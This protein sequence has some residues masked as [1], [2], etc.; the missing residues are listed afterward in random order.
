VDW[1]TL[2][3]PTVGL[4]LLTIPP[5][6]AHS[7]AGLSESLVVTYHPESTQA[8]EE[9]LKAGGNAFDAFIAATLAEYVVAEG[10]TSMAGPLGVLLFNAKNQAV[11]YLDA[12][13]N[14]VRDSRGK[15]GKWDAFLYWL[16]FDRSGKAILVPGAVAGLE[17]LSRKYGA[18]DF[19]KVVRPA[20]DLARHGFILSEFYAAIIQWSEKTL[21]S[22]DYGRRTF[23]RDGRPL[24]PGDR[25][26]QP[27][28]AAFLSKLAEQGAEYM[29]QGEWATRCVEAVRA[30]S[31]RM[32]Q[33][34][35]AA[36]RPDWRVPYKTE[37]RGYELYSPSGRD[38]GGVWVNLA[39]RVIENVPLAS[40][41]HFSSS[42]EALEVVVRT[43]RQVWSELDWLE[44]PRNLD[45]RAAVEAR[46]S[47]SHGQD[48][49]KQ[50]AAQLPV[51]VSEGRG[52]HSYHIIVV[53]KDGN[54]ASGTHTIQS[55]PWGNGV[56]VEGIPLTQIGYLPS[57]SGP[58][59]RRTDALTMHLGFR[60]G[61]FRLATGTI[62]TALL[63][64]NFQLL[65]NLIDYELPPEKA[66][67][68]PR[69]GTIPYDLQGRY[70]ANS[71]WLDPDIPDHVVNQVESR[72]LKFTR[73]GPL[74]C[75]GLDTGL[76][77]VA[78]KQGN[79]ALVGAR[80]PWPGL[81][82]PW[83]ACSTVSESRPY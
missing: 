52:T 77:V 50:V 57:R 20:L 25:L 36:Y 8:G 44:D 75:S 7:E 46:M 40:L 48:L 58:G 65:L 64:T 45:N 60:N 74:V 39:L 66:V 61:K 72:G 68:L 5:T 59:E 10:G 41:G 18:L 13:F 70:D 1:R 4:V 28:V 81:T 30:R 71:N 56:F 3:Y 12:D 16:G 22:S 29:Y 35:L 14:E 82:A 76:G 63:E 78:V 79:G 73:Q 32:V 69:F 33:E 2:L 34:D 27:E 38:W 24:K 83:R 49:W 54:V 42:P 9:I 51:R 6:T 21:K 37:Y 11:E 31:G 55:L 19:A 67:S 47:W 80:I 62:T 23:F 43:T 15:F 26:I 53:D 17:A